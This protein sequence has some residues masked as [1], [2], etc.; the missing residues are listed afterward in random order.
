LTVDLGLASTLPASVFPARADSFFAFY[1]AF[2]A[3]MAMSFRLGRVESRNSSYCDL[4]VRS[5]W[6]TATPRC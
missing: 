6:T 2:L 4:S 3:L 5:V 1:A